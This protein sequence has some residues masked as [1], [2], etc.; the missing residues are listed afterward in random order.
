[1][2][3]RIF[4]KR[5]IVAFSVTFV[6]KNIFTFPG[7]SRCYYF[8][9][10][11]TLTRNPQKYTQFKS[12][13]YYSI[14]S[15]ING[16]PYTKQK[17]LTQSTCRYPQKSQY[18]NFAASGA[19]GNFAITEAIIPPAQINPLNTS[20]PNSRDEKLKKKTTTRDTLLTANENSRVN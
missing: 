7:N 3:N 5:N 17:T 6:R 10:K 2:S 15:A 12:L 1:M 11:K 16:K 20:R 13:S 14:N 4:I 9:I 18:L 8:R 19:R